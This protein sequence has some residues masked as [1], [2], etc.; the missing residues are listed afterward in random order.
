M[1]EC[2]RTAHL[3]AGGYEDH[4][5]MS[6]LSHGG[7][8]SRLLPPALTRCT[9][10]QGG[11]LAH[12]LALGPVSTRGI[13]KG[14]PSIALCGCAYNSSVADKGPTWPCLPQLQPS[15][16]PLPSSGSPS[17]RTSAGVIARG[18]EGQQSQTERLKGSVR[19]VVRVSCHLY[20]IHAIE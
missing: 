5:V 7:H 14:L 2:G 19:G 10:E 1:Q 20:I 6:Q 18:A 8:Q 15:Y 13:E 12:Q 4:P 17:C 11:R 9:G 3:V 16:N